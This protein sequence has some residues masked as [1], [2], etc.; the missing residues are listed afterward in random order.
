MKKL[1]V[2]LIGA[3]GRGT[4][5][6]DIMATMSDMYQV[7]AVA[8]PVKSRREHVRELHGIS[9]DMCF[10]DYHPLLALGKIADIAISLEEAVGIAFFEFIKVV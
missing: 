7:V 4:E 2:I 8:E 6:T 10:E 1:K 5:Y 9:D 3:G